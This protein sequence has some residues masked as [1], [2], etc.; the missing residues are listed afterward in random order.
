MPDA[1]PSP[2]DLVDRLRVV[3]DYLE[4]GPG[5]SILA[6]HQVLNLVGGLAFFSP[7]QVARGLEAV[8]DAL[9]STQF[10][11][12]LGDIL[13]TAGRAP[14][15]EMDAVRHAKYRELVFSAFLAAA[16]EGK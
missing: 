16:G 8:K 5:S 9:A 10:S 12:V 4:L 6:E 13:R 11:M 2:P 7:E 1:A 15:E 14:Q 3:A